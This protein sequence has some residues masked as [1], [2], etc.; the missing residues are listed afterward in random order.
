MRNPIG[1][2]KLCYVDDIV[3]FSQNPKD[4][5]A[6]LDHRYNIRDESALQWYFGQG[7]SNL[8]DGCM[9]TDAAKYIKNTID[10]FEQRH[11]WSL[12]TFDTPLAES[13]SPGMDT[14]QECAPQ[15]ATLFQQIIGVG[16]WLVTIGRYDIAFTVTTLSRFCANPR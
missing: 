10:M 2:W 1:N 13:D 3:I 11:S 8:D 7:L 14:S 5:K 4:T 9:K 6:L 12:R 16:Q 15:D